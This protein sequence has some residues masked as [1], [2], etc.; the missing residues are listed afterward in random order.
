MK[1]QLGAPKVKVDQAELVYVLVLGLDPE[2]LPARLFSLYPEPLAQ[3]AH[4]ERSRRF[5]WPLRRASAAAS[6]G[7]SGVTAIARAGSVCRAL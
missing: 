1:A 7:W 3:T 2:F 6:R 5:C 4:R